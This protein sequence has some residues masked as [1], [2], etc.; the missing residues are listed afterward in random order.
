MYPCHWVFLTLLIV[1]TV[2]IARF[3]R[4]TRG[5]SG[6]KR[7]LV[8]VS[9]AAL[10]LVVVCV[11]AGVLVISP[12]ASW[13][14]EK[15]LHAL[16]LVTPVV[17]RF[18][19]QEIRWPTSW[20]DLQV[21]DT[22]EA[23]SMYSWPDDAEI[24]QDHVTIDFDADLTTIASQTVDEFDAIRPIGAHFPHKDYGYVRSLIETAKTAADSQ[25]KTN[26]EPNN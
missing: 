25:Q 21:V 7:W 11:V 2:V 18:V 23:A 17:E 5:S 14:A 19:H 24:V 3:L 9:V 8:S 16:L 15:G 20:D 26:L 1:F 10:L 6:V 12:L 13:Q 4:S 22:V